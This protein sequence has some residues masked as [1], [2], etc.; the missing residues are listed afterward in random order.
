MVCMTNHEDDEEKNDVF[1]TDNGVN[2]V[3]S[4]ANDADCDANDDVST[5]T[6]KSRHFNLSPALYIFPCLISLFMIKLRA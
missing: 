4:D 6:Y 3:Y 2:Y 5:A 1:I